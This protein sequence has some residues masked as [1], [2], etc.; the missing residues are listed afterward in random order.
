[1]LSLLIGLLVVSTSAPPAAAA[2][3]TL[4]AVGADTTSG[5]RSTHRVRI[6]ASVQPGDV[7]VLMMTWNNARAATTPAGWTSRDLHQGNR[8]SSRV[9][10]RTA[11]AADAG[12]QV[13]VGTGGLA[14]SVL[15]VTAHRSSSGEAVVTAAALDGRNASGNTHT[16]PAVTVTDPG[17]WLVSGWGEKSGSATTW[18][19]PTGAVRRAGGATTG[20]GK[21]SQIVA[22]SADVVDIGP[23][24]GLVA[25]T[26]TSTSRS[27]SLSVVVAPVPGEPPAGPGRR[28]PPGHTTLVPDT[29]DATM[30]RITEGEIWDIEV[31][32]DTAYV[33]GGFSQ[34]QNN[35]PGN[36]TTVPQAL[37]A[38]FDLRTGLIDTGFRPQF[39]G[40]DVRAVEASPDG[41]R[42]FVGGTFD[43]VNGVPQQRI[44]SLDPATG[45]P[46]AGF[47]ARVNAQV[48]SLAATNTTVYLGGRFSFVNG[49]T[50]VGLAAVDATTGA[51]DTGFDNQLSGGIGVNGTLT[52]QQLK[53]TH[54]SSTLVV[55]HT[56]RRIDGQDRY[57]VGLID[58]ASKQLLPWRTRLWEDNLQLVGGIQRIYA[59]D[60]APD[61]SYFVVA[62]GSGGDRPPINDTAVAF[63]FDGGDQREPLW[64]SRAFDSIYSVAIS[65]EA[66]YIGGHFN[67]NESPTAPVPWPGLDNVGYGTGQGLAAY[68]LG[69]AVVRRDHLGALSPSD[70]TALEWHPGST[71]FE[72]NKAMIA[73]RHG[74]LTG[75]DA[76]RQ[77]GAPVGRVAFFDLADLPRASDPDTT[78][79]SPIQGRVVA[80]GAPFVI[81]GQA[82]TSGTLRRVQVEVQQGS[83]YLQD[84]GVTW[85]TFNTIDADLGT[86]AGGRT[87]WSLPVTLASS[88]EVTLRAAAVNGAGQ[89][90]PVKEVRKIEAFSFDDLPPDTRITAPTGTLQA[91]T[92]MVLRGSATDD[93]GVSSVQLYLR[94]VATDRYLTATGELVDDYTTF[95]IDPDVPGAASTTWQ[96]QVVLPAEGDWKVGAMARDSIGQNDTRWAT[97]DYTV[98]SSGQTP[99]VT[100]TAPV[101]VT[102][103][104]SSPTLQMT[105]GGR[106]TFTGTAADD[107]PL[108]TVEVAWRNATTQESL[109][110]DG[111]W[112]ATA[113]AGWHKVSPANLDQTSTSWSFTTPEPLV[114]GSYLFRV[115]ATD[116]QDLTTSTTMQGRI[117]IEVTVPGDAPPDGTLDVIGN[118]AAPTRQLGLTGRATDDRGVAGVRVALFEE[119]TR[120]YLRPDGSLAQGF[121][122]LPATLASPGATSTTW[123]LPVEVPANGTYA[124][125]VLP[126]DTAGQLDASAATARYLVHPGDAAPTLLPTLASPTDGMSFT[127]SRI[128]VSGRAEDDRAIARVEVGIVDSAGRWM[129]S[130]GVFGSTE[131]WIP[132]FLNSPGSPGSNYSYTTPVLPDG[133]YRVRVRPVDANGLTPEARDVGVTVSAPPG[134]A[135]PVPRASITCAQHVC[136][137]DGR[138]SSDENPASLTWL[139]S[140]GDGRT[141]TGGLVTHTYTAPGTVTPSVTVVDEY[142]AS[143]ALTLP[144]RTIVEPTG[145]RAP[146]AVISPPTCVGL[147]CNLSGL[148]SS[149]PD[150]GDV[151][152]W[153]W[154]LTGGVTSTSSAPSRT[155]TAAGTYQVRLTVTDGWGRS[156]TVT[157]QVVV[158]P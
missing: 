135:P 87:P 75:G 43:T 128:F 136:T 29:A 58:T 7:L 74:L 46:D 147:T 145:N 15:S 153:S 154:D 56:A 18:T 47:S 55:V 12:T 143:A 31:I 67:W 38:A 80:T 113:I 60:V 1:M 37:L 71:S 146:T 9:W 158:S 123:Q 106:V 109:A 101:A 105:P 22:D 54:D 4:T 34:L 150:L 149:D 112:G 13:A 53:L 16:T 144:S 51:L 27:T 59:G 132:A 139:W 121:G 70:G 96:H 111:S 50:M 2:G 17:S 72:G 104:T 126:V 25:R 130:T 114:P 133:S 41:T 124:V 89:R 6:P 157:R 52:A 69:D 21:V 118:I 90:D 98:D 77:G 83:R 95:R 137:L 140:L 28:E 64:I 10:T 45:Q 3:E 100:T 138:A 97:R 30:P 39:T 8:F 40:G 61:D 155:F 142:G 33:V 20:S 81:A 110:A 65:E 76:G 152:S 125:S 122:T 108:A 5:S 23:A 85:G 57:G 48:T 79:T 91:S 84:D 151:I 129:A 99:T 19:L 26:S 68:A 24:G 93:N 49:S 102:P 42:L 73:T 86:A 115:R 131:R 127:E 117:P 88:G 63:S 119:G 103:P 62:S 66:V 148:A 11:T 156:Q 14:K 134:N 92:S 44:A 120:R 107:G 141:A 94:E 82:T 78:V 116:K 36:T 32:G 35:A